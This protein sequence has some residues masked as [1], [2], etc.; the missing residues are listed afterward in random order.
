M[1]IGIA[2][3]HGK[4]ALALTRL[5]HD[6]GDQV[7]SIIRDPQQSDDVA[8]A[9]GEPMVFDLEGGQAAELASQL[10]AVDA[11]VFAAG[12]GSG[13]GPERKW[14]VDYGG[15][16]KLLQAAQLNGIARYVM[17]SALGADPESPGD[18]TFSVYLRAK[19][20]ADEEL[21]NSGLDYT[22][23]RPHLLTDDPGDGLVRIA[24][25]MKRSKVPRDDVALVLAATLHEPGTIKKLFEVVDGTDSIEGALRSLT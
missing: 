24:E 22:I 17:I 5:L 14:T 19:G 3:G 21:I 10:G 8:E 18:D 11:V 4:I 20:K 2:K 23:V 12:A 25:Q 15:A 6:R 7:A 13:S 16:V 9:G 1:K